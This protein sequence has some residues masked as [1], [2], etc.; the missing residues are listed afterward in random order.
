MRLCR[1]RCYYMTLLLLDTSLM[2]MMV[3]KDNWE[4]TIHLAVHRR[5]INTAFIYDTYGHL[6][7]PAAILRP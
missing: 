4:P 5:S 3:V 1:T 7:A 2:M 6:A